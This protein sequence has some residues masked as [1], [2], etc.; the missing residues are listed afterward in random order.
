MS[1]AT[2]PDV[3]AAFAILGGRNVVPVEPSVVE[4]AASYEEGFPPITRTPRI[5]GGIPPSGLDMNGIL[6]DVSAHTAWLA[7]GRLYAYN[8]AVS[9][10]QSGYGVG[11]VL[12]SASVRGRFFLNITA[13]NTNNP[14]SV[15]TGW[16]PFSLAAAATLVQASTIPAGTTSD[17]ALTAGVG[18]LDVTANV[19]GSTLTGMVAGYDGQEV[20]ISN[21]HAS[22]LLTLAAMTGSASANQ[23]RLP[24]DIALLFRMSQTF[25]YSAALAVWVPK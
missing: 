9:A 5:A 10:A 12:Q 2:P 3:V 8:A 17:L 16:I 25:K 4:G 23:Y 7:A 19:A 22:G 13:G 14:D 11:A 6:Y 24:A 18:V 1:V 15:T 21:L 20:T